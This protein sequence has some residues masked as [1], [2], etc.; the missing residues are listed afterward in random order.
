MMNTIRRKFTNALTAM[1]L[2][3]ATPKVQEQEAPVSSGKIDRDKNPIIERKPRIYGMSGDFEFVPDSERQ[4]PLR[5]L[6]EQLDNLELP[7]WKIEPLS[8]DRV[9]PREER[10]PSV[11]QE[12]IYNPYFESLLRNFDNKLEGILVG[13]KKVSSSVSSSTSSSDGKVTDQSLGTELTILVQEGA[14]NEARQREV[15]INFPGIVLNDSVGNWVTY[16]KFL[17]LGLP[18]VFKLF[19]ENRNQYESATLEDQDL[20]RKY[21]GSTETRVEPTDI[22]SKSKYGSLRCM[23]NDELDHM[24]GGK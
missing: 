22:F 12:K 17:G 3:L 6:S 24:Y 11:Y 21:S 15:T 1:S 19:P 20:K 10:E 18:D 23:T 5:R 9:V 16:R 13:I 8:E 2:Y 14:D 7:I 4:N